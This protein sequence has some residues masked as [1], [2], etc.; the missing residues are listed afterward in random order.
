[1]LGGRTTSP[2]GKALDLATHHL[3]YKIVQV[4]AQIKR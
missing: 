3:D 1:M 2:Q 4:G